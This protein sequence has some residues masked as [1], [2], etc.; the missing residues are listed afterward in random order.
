MLMRDDAVVNDTSLVQP[1][2]GR[3]ISHGRD[4]PRLVHYD[5]PAWTGVETGTAHCVAAESATASVA[6]PSIPGS[7]LADWL[8]QC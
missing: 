5:V 1:G 4:R 8:T 7:R 2:E 6:R 3:A